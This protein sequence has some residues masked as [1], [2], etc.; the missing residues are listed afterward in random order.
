MK[1][2]PHWAQLFQ[3]PRQLHGS[4]TCAVV[5]RKKF[6]WSLNLVDWPKNVAD[7]KGFFVV[8]KIAF[9]PEM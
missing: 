9:F 8:D 4:M 6:W 5:Q 1:Q 3:F 7:I 2:M